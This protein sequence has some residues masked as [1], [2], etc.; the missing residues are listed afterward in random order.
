MHTN[1]FTYLLNK[2]II[3]TLLQLKIGILVQPFFS[4]D[5]MCSVTT[6]IFT[7]SPS[8]NDNLCLCANAKAIH[9]SANI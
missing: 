5:V 4:F 8:L 3:F 2:Y 9:F 7:M 1:T 6:V